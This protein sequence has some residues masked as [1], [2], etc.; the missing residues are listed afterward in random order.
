MILQTL[1]LISRPVFSDKHFTRRQTMSFAI[2][3]CILNLFFFCCAPSPN[4]E[5]C[6][7]NQSEQYPSYKAKKQFCQK[8]YDQ[9]LWLQILFQ[10]KFL[11]NFDD[12]A[13]TIVKL[14]FGTGGG[15]IRMHLISKMSLC[16]SPSNLLGLIKQSVL[17]N[18]NI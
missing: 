4:P 6:T 13:A 5:R 17:L 9:P 3:Y 11:L 16:L 2:L 1:Y 15:I 8:F 7:K 10:T 14:I 12:I 18:V